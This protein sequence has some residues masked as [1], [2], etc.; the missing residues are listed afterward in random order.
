MAWLV[1]EERVLASVE[2]AESWQARLRGVIGRDELDGAFIISPAKSVHT[3]GVNFPI[4]VAYC[5]ADFNV[6]DVVTMD[7]NRLG[8]PRW[9]ANVV[10]EAA[11]GSFEKWGVKA[12]DKL[13]LRVNEDT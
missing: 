12:G 7:P 11:K 1:V 9:K 13:Q 6:L 8:K 5:D 3:F 2:I 4:D 10:I